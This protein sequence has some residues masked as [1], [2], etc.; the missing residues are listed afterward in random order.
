MPRKLIT[1]AM[2]SL[3]LV[4]PFIILELINRR[5]FFT[6]FPVA[7]FGMMWLLTFS[8]ILLLVPV[9]RNLRNKHLKNPVSLAAKVVLLVSIASIWI[10]LLVDQLP[11]FLGVP[12]CD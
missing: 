9:A 8:F 4:L 11:C 3:V 5:N 7:L 12:N 2:I 6:D 10:R 1:H